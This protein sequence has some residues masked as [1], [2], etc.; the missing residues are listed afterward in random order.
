MKKS[1]LVIG[2]LLMAVAVFC[3]ASAPAVSAAPAQAPAAAVTPVA[4]LEPETCVICHKA[5]GASHETYY[6][7]LYQDGVIKVT[8]L[9]YSFTAPDTT[10]VTFKMTKNG[11][12]FNGK[13]A[14]NLAI[15]FVPFDGKNFQFADG[16]PRLSLKG[17]LTYDA[18]TTTSTLVALKPTDT[19]YI[20]Y[21]DVS[22]VNG[23]IAVYGTDEIVGSL[24][25]RVSQG[26]YPYAALLQT[27]K[28]VTYTSVANNDGCVKCH[29]DP[30]LKHG[31]IYAEVGKDPKTDFI[32]CKV[33]HLDNGP[34][35]HFEWQLSADDPEKAAAYNAG[36]G[37][38]KLT[39]AETAKYSYPTRLMNDVHMSHAMEFP[40]PQSMANCT[41]CHE[42]KLD[43]VLTDANFKY[44]TCR[45]CH[46]QTG[47]KGPG[48][49]TTQRALA[50][51]MPAAI[52]K[53]LGADLTK[54]D[55]SGCH[56]AGGS[57]KTFKQIHTGY[58]QTIYTADG[59]KYSSVI[60]VS[61]DKAA[62][63]SKTNIITIDFSAH[64]DKAPADLKTATI[65]PTLL[66]GLYGWETKD[67]IIGPHE[68]L[69]DDN[70]DGK[71]DSKDGRNLESVIGTTDNPRVKTVSAANGKW[72]VT[73]DLTAWK[74]LLANGSVKRVEIGVMPNLTVKGTM[75][76]LNAPSRTFNLGTNK[77][78]DKFYAPIIKIAD[79]CN[80]CH[81]ALAT[82]FH[83]PDRGGNMVVCRLCHI[84]KAG[85]SHLEMQSR[86]LDSYV[87]AIHSGQ[88][89][90]IGTI[91]FADPAAKMK[92]TT[93][94]EL[95]FPKHGI[96]NCEACHTKGSYD[97]PTQSQSLP[98]LLS[99]SATV[100]STT[101]A[102][103]VV[104]SY[105]T[106]PATRVCGSCHRATAINED[107]FGKLTVLNLH[108]K[109]GGYLIDAGKTPDATL[110]DVINQTMAIFGK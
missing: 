83:T 73:V 26:K 104:P 97:V 31:Y 5:S 30:Y 96:T 22:A 57:A 56:K 64:Q 25:V 20:K 37:T 60:T 86:S 109:H 72:S 15:Y 84:T 41:T 42:G 77:F 99:A 54:V 90:D 52:H 100:T 107:D 85:G 81:D 74:D 70:K 14:D 13:D 43:K 40:Y 6:D 7:Q 49:D 16:S 27:G 23:V 51:I 39:E 9:K 87:H 80:T 21:T 32:T 19:G 62:Y 3:V 63:D 24:P 61:V 103:G 71:L 4:T 98:G 34:G 92:Y 79:G 53:S 102:M 94:T 58:D 38:Y 59:V 76:A 68:R 66:V 69:I 108:F 45:S 47:S 29:S 93:D 35:G 28:G 17:K 36:E 75:L 50:T 44:D 12:P 33:C 46:P 78:D 67:F 2:V 91:N 88:A 89:F 11:A 18:G 8:D 95:P 110:L 105:V 106:G 82:T 10:V 101:R 55:C 1:L 48:F 65:T